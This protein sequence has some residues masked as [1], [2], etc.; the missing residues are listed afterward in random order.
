MKDTN[1]VTKTVHLGTGGNSEDMFMAGGTK[2]RER[3]LGYNTQSLFTAD[4]SFC[5]ED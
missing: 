4:L 5:V 2:D 3:R 1:Y